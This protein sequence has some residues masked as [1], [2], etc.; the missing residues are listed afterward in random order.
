VEIPPQDLFREAHWKALQ[1]DFLARLV[2]R[3][4]DLIP[5]E[6]LT[7]ILQTFQKMPHSDPEMISLDRI[8]GSVGRYRDFTRDFLPR[9]AAMMERWARI[10]QNMSSMEGLP[11][12]ELFKVGDVYF[13][14]DGNHRVSVA[15]ANG[16]DAIPAY[17]TEYPVDVGLEPGDTLDQAIIKVERA[18]FLGQTKLDRQ[19]PGVEIYFTK[20]GGYTRLLDH[21]AIHRRLMSEADSKG[22][23]PSLEEAALDWYT[24]TY[25]PIV[26]VIRERQLPKRFPGRTAADLYVW[27][28]GAIMEMY[29]LFGE[30]VSPDEGAAL[31]EIRAPSLFRQMVQDLMKRLLALSRVFTGVPG[32]IPDWVTQTFEWGDGAFTSDGEVEKS[33]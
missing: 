7:G 5:F 20:P 31:L 29:R 19:V 11:P 24:N 3:S 26:T 25:Q 10:D 8:V 1:Q 23:E 18:R 2:G 4:N 28:W 32:D 16:F 14:A 21:V 17:V 30:E 6:A 9:S 33:G 12:I 13:V 15:R 22:Q 27:I